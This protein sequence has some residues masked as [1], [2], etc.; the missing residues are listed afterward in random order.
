MSLKTCLILE[1]TGEI[2]V[3]LKS[4]TGLPKQCFRV[5]YGEIRLT[6]ESL[7]T[8]CAILHNMCIDHISFN[9]MMMTVMLM[10]TTTMMVMM[11]MT[12]KSFF[13]APRWTGIYSITKLTYIL[14]K[15]THK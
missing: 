1:N 10:S 5:L 11:M 6:S 7:I 9:L 2:A 15:L 12:S 8:V 4:I 3:L 13:N 14:G